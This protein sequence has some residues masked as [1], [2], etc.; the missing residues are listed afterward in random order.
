MRNA[1]QSE[2]LNF[3]GHRTREKTEKIGDKLCKHIDKE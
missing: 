1:K 2:F 3:Y